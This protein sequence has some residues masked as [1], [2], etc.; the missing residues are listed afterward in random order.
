MTFDNAAGA[1]IGDQH[2]TAHIGSLNMAAN[3]NSKAVTEKM[4]ESVR[5]LLSQV[6]LAHV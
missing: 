2:H 4:F 6:V 1:S 5:K 3:G